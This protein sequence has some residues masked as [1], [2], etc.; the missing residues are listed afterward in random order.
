M[1]IVL[2]HVDSPV[3]KSR[4]PDGLSFEMILRFK[5]WPGFQFHLHLLSENRMCPKLCWTTT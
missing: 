5:A 3:A 2:A 4:L 1:S